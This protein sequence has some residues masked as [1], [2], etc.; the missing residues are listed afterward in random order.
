VVQHVP[1]RGA[2]MVAKQIQDG[3]GETGKERPSMGSGRF[4]FKFDDKSC[5]V[6]I[7]PWLDLPVDQSEMQSDFGGLSVL[8]GHLG[9]Q[10]K[11]GF[12]KAIDSVW[13]E[14]AKGF[15]MVSEDSSLRVR[16]CVQWAKSRS[17]ATHIFD[18]RENFDKENVTTDQLCGDDTHVQV[19]LAGLQQNLPKVTIGGLK[20]TI[21][22][23][24]FG[25]MIGL[26]DEY[27]DPAS[28]VS[29]LPDSDKKSWV[30]MTD[31]LWD[32]M[33]QLGARAGVQVNPKELCAVG[34]DTKSQNKDSIMAW[35][36]IVKAHHM[37]PVLEALEV[38]T[39]K[40]WMILAH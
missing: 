12:E 11:A 2:K 4:W 26:P 22:A 16:F 38:N 6:I 28:F 8:D 24:E 25:H 13:N 36:S 17:E 15:R 18:V 21:N 29:T 9:S 7:R 1:W 35:G 34:Q 14:G 31:Q 5:D 30:F 23:H 32:H 39:R 3:I 37:L 10:F 40:K 33:T 19:C 20:S 27:L